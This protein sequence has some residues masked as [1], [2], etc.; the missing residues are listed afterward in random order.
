MTKNERVAYLISNFFLSFKYFFGYLRKI[1]FL[2]SFEIAA[3]SKK[4]FKI[5]L[6]S[7]FQSLKFV[8]SQINL[9]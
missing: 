2:V 8:Q 9:I 3:F 4:F 1:D 6:F 7:T 5:F